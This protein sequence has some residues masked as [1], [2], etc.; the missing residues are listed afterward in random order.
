MTTMGGILARVSD[1]WRA[2]RR[3]VR[4]GSGVGYMYVATV[5]NRAQ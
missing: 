1:G 4:C 3:P 2:M 5:N